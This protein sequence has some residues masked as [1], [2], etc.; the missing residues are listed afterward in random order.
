M[1]KDAHALHQDWNVR[2]YGEWRGSKLTPSSQCSGDGQPGGPEGF[3][4][5]ILA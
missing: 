1:R 5:G 3:S 2:S 4:K